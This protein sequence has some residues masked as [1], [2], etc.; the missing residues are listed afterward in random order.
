MRAI[1]RHVL[2][3]SS[4]MTMFIVVT[5]ESKG[6]GRADAAAAGGRQTHYSKK[7]TTMIPKRPPSSISRIWGQ[8]RNKPSPKLNGAPL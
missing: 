2:N 3:L 7:T 1:E 8:H 6:I 4:V 5:C